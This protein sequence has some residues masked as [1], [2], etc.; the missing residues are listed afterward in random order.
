MRT[1]LSRENFSICLRSELV[2]ETGELFAGTEDRLTSD[3]HFLSRITKSTLVVPD[4]YQVPARSFA[5]FIIC[6]TLS[7]DRRTLALSA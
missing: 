3:D 7:T 5:L 1:L 4:E 2:R 6:S